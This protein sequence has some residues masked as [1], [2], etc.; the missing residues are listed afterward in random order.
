M[1]H[2][3][4]IR[5]GVKVMDSA[6]SSPQGRVRNDIVNTKA[7]VFVG[8][9]V[10]MNSISAGHPVMG[11]P[12]LEVQKVREMMLAVARRTERSESK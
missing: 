10:P 9:H 3:K 11:E 7:D 2:W 6:Y 4:T 1:S 8:N 5:P 12:I